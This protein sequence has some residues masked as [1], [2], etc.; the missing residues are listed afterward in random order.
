MSRVS[1]G[2]G[3]SANRS[4]PPFTYC[5]E[6]AG[7]NRDH[8]SKCARVR[9]HGRFWCLAFCS[10]GCGSV[11]VGGELRRANIDSAALAYSHFELRSHRAVAHRA[12]HVVLMEFGGASRANL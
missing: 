4:G 10:H 7:H 3:A 2:A 5:D 12:E 8:W 6:N 11:E 1:H 9:C